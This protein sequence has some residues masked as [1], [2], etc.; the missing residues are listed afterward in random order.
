LNFGGPYNAYLATKK[1]YLRQ[2]PGRIVGETVDL[3]GKRAF[4]MTLRAREQDIRREK[5]TSNICTN[6]NLNVTAANI[7]LSLMG[8]EGLY[9]T[10]LLNTKMAHYLE[11]RLLESGQFEKVFD[12]PFYNEFLLKSK[13]PLSVVKKNLLNH[14]FIPPLDIAKFYPDEDLKN[15][16]LFAVTEIWNRNSLNEVVRILSEEGGE[17]CN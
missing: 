16:L 8:T 9:Q 17:E 6:H 7:Y 13:N 1:P 15:V 10:A 11:S 5:A 12:Y 2:L 14:Q 3:E 4:V